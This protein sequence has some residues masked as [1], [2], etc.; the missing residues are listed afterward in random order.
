[1]NI[2]GLAAFGTMVYYMI[3]K[4]SY[5][6][7]M[8]YKADQET[9]INIPSVKHY[10]EISNEWMNPE[11]TGSLLNKDINTKVLSENGPFG[12]PRNIYEGIGGSMT[13]AYGENLTKF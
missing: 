9:I 7:N 13:I 10:T 4:Q 6:N 11:R 2:L 8:Y 3:N 5:M 12:L 1:M